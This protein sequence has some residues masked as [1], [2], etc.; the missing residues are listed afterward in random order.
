MEIG[1]Y[2]VIQFCY[3]K[4]RPSAVLLTWFIG[5]SPLSRILCLLKLNH[6]LVTFLLLYGLVGSVC[7][8]LLYLLRLSGAIIR[9]G[10]RSRFLI[11]GVLSR[12]LDLV[13]NSIILSIVCLMLVVNSS[14]VFMVCFTNNCLLNMLKYL[15]LY[16]MWKEVSK[17]F[18]SHDG[19]HSFIT[20]VP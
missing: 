5:G 19:S 14:F 12:N 8:I 11:C 2:I 13:A 10:E 16:S 1:F 7:G 18:D 17:Q 4:S 9:F 6:I 15:H 3:F 20:S